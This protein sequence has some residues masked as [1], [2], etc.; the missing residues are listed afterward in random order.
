MVMVL[1]YLNA[2]S[3]TVALAGETANYIGVLTLLIIDW[4]LEIP[5]IFSEVLRKLRSLR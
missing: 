3:G 1:L 2:I 5:K 4:E